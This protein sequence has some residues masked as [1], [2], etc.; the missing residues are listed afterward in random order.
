MRFK[1]DWVDSETKNFQRDL[2]SKDI[3]FDNKFFVKL[4]V[5]LFFIIAFQL[6]SYNCEAQQHVSRM[7]PSTWK[8]SNENCGYENYEGIS[9]CAL[10][11]KKRGR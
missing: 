8:C 9:H 10:C 3:R 2:H 5:I 4:T 1:N 6:C 7:F 11:G